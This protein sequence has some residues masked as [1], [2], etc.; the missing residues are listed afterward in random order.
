MSRMSR[1]ALRAGIAVLFGLLGA[2][3]VSSFI[4]LEAI[5]SIFRASP[6]IVGVLIAI[7][8]FFVTAPRRH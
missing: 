2:A 7:L 3:A 5:A 1:L 8:V 6:T 4:E